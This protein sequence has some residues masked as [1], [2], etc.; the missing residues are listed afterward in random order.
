MAMA[1]KPE[2]V[3]KRLEARNTSF[4]GRHPFIIVLIFRHMHLREKPEVNQHL[5]N[6]GV[7]G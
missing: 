6:E 3:G 1:K 7:L 4:G 2:K 5:S